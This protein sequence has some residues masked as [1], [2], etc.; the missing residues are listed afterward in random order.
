MVFVESLNLITLM[1]IRVFCYKYI[2]ARHIKISGTM[3]VGLIFQITSVAGITAYIG[4]YAYAAI[5]FLMALESASLP[6]PSEVVLPLIG[7]LAFKGTL[8]IYLGFAAAVTGSMIGIAVDYYIAYYLGKD[9]VYK[10]LRLLHIKEESVRSFEEWF[11]KNGAFAVFVSRLLPVVRGLISLPAGFAQMPQKQFFLY[12]F[13]GTLVWDTA[14]ILFGYYALSTKN[15][16]ML[17]GSV[18]A[19][20]IVLYV[21][22]LYFEKKI[23][24]GR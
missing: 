5:L 10:H 15:V 6:V 3:L 13:A 7:L 23:R 22:Y 11:R 9:V 18:A 8:N 2:K 16:Y 19:F 21:L 20:A 24:K 1:A 12:S 14:L 4:K 17:F